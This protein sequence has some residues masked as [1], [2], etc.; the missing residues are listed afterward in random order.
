VITFTTVIFA[1][2]YHRERRIINTMERNTIDDMEEDEN[3]S[4]DEH[5]H[6]LQEECG[7]CDKS[8]ILDQLQTML[9]QERNIYIRCDYIKKASSS[10]SRSYADAWCRLKMVQWCYQVID[11]VEL[12][13]DTV[14]IAISYLDRFF[15]TS[16]QRAKQVLENRKEYQLAVMTC[17]FMAI[18]LFE[19]GNLSQKAIG[20]L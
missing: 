11:F 10:N 14:F 7:C 13:R 17:L 9:I 3:I 2:A 1:A 6:N 16:T 12:S 8:Q 5:Q 4:R 19:P 15:S 18:K 20:A